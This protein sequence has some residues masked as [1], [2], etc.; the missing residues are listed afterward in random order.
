[1]YLV[2]DESL[3]MEET[4]FN[5]Y[6]RWAESELDK[7]TFDRLNYMWGTLPERSK[8]KAKAALCELILSKASYEARS[9]AKEIKSESVGSYSVSYSTPA[10]EKQLT[11]ID[12]REIIARYMLHTGLMYKGYLRGEPYG[13]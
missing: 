2:Y 5:K 9:E 1:M 11:P 3:G 4:V 10:S 13:V 6:I 8:S 12:P 7:Y